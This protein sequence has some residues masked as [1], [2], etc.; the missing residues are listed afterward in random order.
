M[1]EAVVLRIWARDAQAGDLLDPEGED[2]R[3]IDSAKVGTKYVTLRDGTGRQI[4]HRRLVTDKI[5]IER[6]M[7]TVEDRRADHEADRERRI[8]EWVE[9]VLERADA[10]RLRF[11]ERLP[12]FGIHIPSEWN[13]L[14]RSEAELYAV[15]RIMNRYEGAR[16]GNRSWAKSYD[17]WVAQW[18]AHQDGRSVYRSTSMLNN[19]FND[20]TAEVEY[21]IAKESRFQPFQ[22]K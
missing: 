1:P 9:A 19:V 8:G 3:E 2:P 18:T 22:E 5:D 10:A 12:V 21:R 17:E 6:I 4:G 16:K 20:I 11:V 7:P 14:I 13:A 15:T